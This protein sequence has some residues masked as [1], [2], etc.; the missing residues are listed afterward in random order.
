MGWLAFFTFYPVLVLFAW[1]VGGWPMG[2]IALLGP[3]IGAAYEWL[4]PTPPTEPPIV[5]QDPPTERQLDFIADLREEREIPP[6]LNYEPPTKEDASI[7]IEML[8]DQPYR[9]Y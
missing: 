9:K 5:W 1:V 8:L 3:V 6:M 7:L 4:R 2:L